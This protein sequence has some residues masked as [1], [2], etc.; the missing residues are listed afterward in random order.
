MGATGNSASPITSVIRLLMKAVLGIAVIGIAAFAGTALYNATDEE[1]SAEAKAMLAAPQMGKVED[2]NGY[3]AFLGMGAPKGADQLA[4][5]RKAAAMFTAQARPDAVRSAQ[6]KEATRTHFKV[7]DRRT[8][9]TP[10]MRDCL[11]EAKTD[12]AAIATR[13]A[14]GD[15]AELLARYRKVREAPAFA[16]LYMGA[17][18]LDLPGSYLALNVGAA[19]S[20]AY[21][22]A[23]AA[24][25]DIDAAV[26]E[27]EREVAFHRR[28]LSG[29][30]SIVT[31]LTGGNLLAQDLLT[32]SALVR[33]GTDAIAPH[34]VRLAA[35]TRPQAGAASMQ[36]AFG[37]LA[38]EKVTWARHWRAYLRDNGDL[39]NFD[40]A[41]LPLE[42]F[43][44]SLYIRP[45]ET[46]NTVASFMRTEAT[47]ASAPATQFEQAAAAIRRTNDALLVYPWYMEW[48]NPVGKEWAEA[49]TEKLADYAA[50]MIDLQALERM[51]D[52]QVALAGRG[53]GDAAAIAAFVSG[54]GAKSHPDPYTGQAFAFDPAKRLLSFEP[55]QKGRWAGQLKKRY[56][57]AAI[58]I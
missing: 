35:L 34:Q 12:G 39:T 17:L 19:L 27:L 29:G 31:V 13:L 32:I 52:L 6:W 58:L 14:D 36:A 37:Y 23:K 30:K 44:S 55:R 41:S 8:W 24:A 53:M 15:N 1:L 40:R 2:Q 10:Q 16:E 51:V 54:E 47:I 50:W 18:T 48:R 21:I 20:R 33:H 57:R 11:A 42:N 25:G 22:E 45:N 46:A 4:W 9:C 56:G 43:I 5:G 49:F 38:H 3:V 28:I 7:P 26:A